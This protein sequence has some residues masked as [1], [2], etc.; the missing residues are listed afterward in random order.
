MV[1]IDSGKLN[2]FISQWEE[3]LE[4]RKHEILLY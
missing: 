2:N 4:E 3:E 1:N